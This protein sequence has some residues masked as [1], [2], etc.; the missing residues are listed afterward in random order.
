MRSRLATTFSVTILGVVALAILSSLVT[1]YAAWRVNI[2]L[3]EAWDDRPG[4]AADEKAETIP[5]QEIIEK[6]NGRMRETTWVV[7]VSSIVTLLLGGF[8]LWLF[9]YRVLFPLRGMVADAKLYRGARQASD[10][11]TRGRR[12]AN[13]R[14][15]PAEPDVG[16]QRHAFPIG[17]QPQSTSGG[18]KAGL[19]RQDRRQRGP[20]DPQSAHGDEDVALLDPGGGPGKRRLGRESSASSRKRSCDWRVSSG[21][22]SIFPDL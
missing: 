12:I 15:P 7:G 13:D 11:D 4:A 21:I 1:L 17:A 6:I 19:R 10:K 9:F 5:R 22:S 18:R 20:R 2:R 14:R 8:L 16:R 3:E